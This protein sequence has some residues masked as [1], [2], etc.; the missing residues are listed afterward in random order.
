MTVRE[1]SVHNTENAKKHCF[2]AAAILLFIGESI[3]T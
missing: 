2:L 1:D 3:I